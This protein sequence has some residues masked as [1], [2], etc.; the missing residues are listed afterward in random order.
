MLGPVAADVTVTWTPSVIAQTPCGDAVIPTN[1]LTASS[2]STI[3]VASNGPPVVIDRTPCRNQPTGS[4]NS[5]SGAAIARIPL[6]SAALSIPMASA[7]S[8]RAVPT[9]V[10]TV[11]S[12]S[13]S[14]RNA[15]AGTA[16]AAS[17]TKPSTSGVGNKATGDKPFGRNNRACP[18]ATSRANASD[19]GSP[20]PPL[21]DA[22]PAAST[23]TPACQCSRPLSPVAVML[24]VRA[25]RSAWALSGP[26]LT[27]ATSPVTVT[28]GTM[29]ASAVSSWARDGAAANKGRSCAPAS[30]NRCATASGTSA[31]PVPVIPAA[32]S[33]AVNRPAGLDGTS[34]ASLAVNALSRA[35]ASGSSGCSSISP[36]APAGGSTG[37]RAQ[38]A[39]RADP[40]PNLSIAS[41]APPPSP[42]L[43]RPLIRR[44]SRARAPPTGVVPG[45]P[46][47]QLSVSATEKSSVTAGAT[48]TAPSA[49][50][51][52]PMLNI[53]D[54][55]S[56]MPWPPGGVRNE[57]GSH[58]P[59]WVA[60]GGVRAAAARAC[61]RAASPPAKTAVIACAIPA[62]SSTPKTPIAVRP[63][64]IARSGRVASSS[65]AA[66]RP[67]TASNNPVT[68]ARPCARSG[69]S[70]S[71]R[72]TAGSNAFISRSASPETP[73]RA[74]SNV[75][76]DHGAPSVTRWLTAATESAATRAALPAPA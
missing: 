15:S 17:A 25:V 73:L 49:A 53:T 64:R 38:S 36:V 50:A 14:T 68:S 34:A 28:P 22:C 20:I 52:D 24:I 46:I 71:V 10:S 43:T 39:P 47:S 48:V 8:S 23:C 54:P 44:S 41:D 27:L 65:V 55:A 63:A 31:P 26:K 75:A 6:A 45:P 9:P 7:R 62:P 33:S 37:S 67:R 16:A 60:A 2:R 70:G 66:D 61:A 51:I 29:P 4:S 1:G 76:A 58:T 74:V 32:V 21:T 40:S 19:A 72:S 57:N 42:M 59:R 11:R 18:A 3:F 13:S 12:A 30:C 5:P 69:S 35:W 56:V